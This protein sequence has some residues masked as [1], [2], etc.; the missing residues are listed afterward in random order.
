MRLEELEF[1]NAPAAVAANPLANLAAFYATIQPAVNT[2]SALANQA[3]AGQLSLY[4][5]LAGLEIALQ[6]D[7]LVTSEF[8]SA[9]NQ[10]PL[11][12]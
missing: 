12:V 7:N 1:R 5:N 2:V 10:Q 3:L 8:L 11:Q 4:Q 6:L 9:L